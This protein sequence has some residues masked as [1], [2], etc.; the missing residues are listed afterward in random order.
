VCGNAGKVHVELGGGHK[1]IAAADH[2]SGR[3]AGTYGWPK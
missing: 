3:D 2:R 1:V